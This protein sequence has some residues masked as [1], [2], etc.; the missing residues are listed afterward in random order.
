M[1]LRENLERN[2]CDLCMT[3]DI[4]QMTLRISQ[5]SVAPVTPDASVDEQT[6]GLSV[7]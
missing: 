4:I 3:V 7:Q 1:Q 6:H 5:P 2:A